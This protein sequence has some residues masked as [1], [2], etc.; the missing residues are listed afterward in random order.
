MAYPENIANTQPATA[1]S[2]DQK[3]FAE[4]SNEQG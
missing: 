1:L 3:M 4:H 2:T